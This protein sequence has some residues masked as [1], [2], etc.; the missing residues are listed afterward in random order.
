MPMT[1]VTPDQ[2]HTDLAQNL[3]W[4]QVDGANY[5]VQNADKAYSI[6]SPSAG[7]LR[8]EVSGG[9]VW[10][11]VDPSWKERSEIA[12]VTQYANKTS[13][14]VTY[15]F[16]IE[17]GAKNTSSGLV[18]GQ[19]HQNDGVDSNSP[20]FCIALNG[21]KIAVCIGYTDA[22]GKVVYAT[23]YTSAADVVRGHEYDVKIDATFDTGSQ[24]HLAVWIDGQQVANYW[25]PLGYS[26]QSSVYWKAG[27]YR[28]NSK[29]EDI[30]IQ[31]SDLNIDTVAAP[32]KPNASAPNVSL[33]ATLAQDTGI[34]STDLVT[35]NGLVTL[36]GTTASGATVTVMDGNTVLGT[37]TASAAGT[38]SLKTALVEGRHALTASATKEG[39]TGTSSS[40]LVVVDKT[41]PIAPKINGLSRDT[42]IAGDG[43]T[44]DGRQSF[45]GVGEAGSTIKLTLDGKVV[46]TTVV[47]TDGTWTYDNTSTLL[48]QGNHTLYANSTDVAGNIS[49]STNAYYFSVD[50]VAPVLK[51]ATVAQS[52]DTTTIRGTA[53]GLGTVTIRDASTNVATSVAS[54]TVWAITTGGATQAHSYQILADDRASNTIASNL[55]IG[56]GAADTLVVLQTDDTLW[57]GAGKDVFVLDTAKASA[58]T[59]LDFTVGQD[60]ISLIGFNQAKAVLKAIDSSHWSVSDGEHSAVITTWASLTMSDFTFAPPAA[61]SASVPFIPASQA[62]VPPLVVT[63]VNTLAIRSLSNDTGTAGD[64]ITSVARQALNGTSDAGVAVKIYADGKLLGATVADANGSWIYDNTANELS[65]GGHTLY[66]VAV[67]AQGQIIK[68]SGLF[69]ATIDSI[70]PALK[71]ANINQSGDTTTI[72]GT[73]ESLGVVIAKEGATTITT[74]VAANG[75]WGLTVGGAQAHVLEIT[76]QD[77]AGNTTGARITIG[78]ANADQLTSLSANDLLWGGA[79]KDIF[80]FDSAKTT[81][82]TV[83]DFVS[84]QDKLKLVGFD[85]AHTTVT[86]LDSTRWVMTDGVHT[87]TIAFATT[88][89]LMANDLLFA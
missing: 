79:G 73:S 8:F 2:W 43:I 50:S 37:A 67:N 23:L 34:S 78:T 11:Q 85:Q 17:P 10:A 32:Q 55:I 53:E 76:G 26:T 89:S 81:G 82:G 88:T 35:S 51:V 47:G 87:E 63:P 52:G 31:Y 46:G 84:G 80:I 4:M 64:G 28:Q 83:M 25:G 22:S 70:A 38:W 19:F 29:G 33:L 42:G 18:M 60:K 7:V 36:S 16:M 5:W 72:R 68:S 13:L 40:T 54:N 57:G 1:I 48:A 24:G 27:I 45:K 71:I 39:L 62:K 58:A 14:E 77:I 30:A 41:A 65:Q 20:P 6:T 66:A 15:G 61:P 9:D 49:P 44:S 86:S 75:V 3:Y 69:Y 12:G 59:L 56:T 21:E 74:P